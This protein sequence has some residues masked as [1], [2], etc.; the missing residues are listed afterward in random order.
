MDLDPRCSFFVPVLFLD[1]RHPSFKNFNS[2][3]LVDVVRV[4]SDVNDQLQSNGRTS[5]GHS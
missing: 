4:K 3:V 1:C 2:V 5:V